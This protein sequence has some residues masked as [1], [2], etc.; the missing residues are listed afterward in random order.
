MTD[1]E[2][3]RRNMV[4]SQI[5]PSDVTDRRIIRAMLSLPREVFVPA[6][7]KEMAYMDREIELSSGGPSGATER[8]LMAP[9][10]FARLVQL[11]SVRAGDIVL[12]IGCGT[13]YSTAVLASLAESVVGL[14]SDKNLSDRANAL[15]SELNIDN[16]AIVNGKLEL[17]HAS[18]S[19][20]DVILI[21]GSV[22]RIPDEIKAQLR[23]EGRLVAIVCNTLASQAVIY[24]RHGAKVSHYPAFDA[25][26]EPI[27]SFDASPVF[28]F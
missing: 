24:R 23:D 12:D 25:N 10:P 7:I 11:A 14:E 15:L 4:E 20:Y 13:G 8:Y 28:E 27:P 19:P 18:E 16:A 17:G 6:S 21:N 9:M 22:T 3:A 26:A 5:R 2:L 1:F